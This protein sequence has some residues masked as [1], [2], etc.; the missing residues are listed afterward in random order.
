MLSGRSR[1]SNKEVSISFHSFSRV[2][3]KLEQRPCDPAANS[4]FF[5]IFNNTARSGE[6][7]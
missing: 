2:I 4:T 1:K 7:D 3:N 5:C 6:N